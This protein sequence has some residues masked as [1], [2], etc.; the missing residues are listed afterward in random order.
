MPR[1]GLDRD[2]V[3]DAAEEILARDGAGELTLAKVARRLGVRTPSLYH[4]VDGLDGLRRAL[5]LRG[6][7]GLR[8][9]LAE[10]ALGR[11]G[12]DA[13]RALAHAYR[14]WASE[15][16]GLYE[17]TLR[18]QSAADPEDARAAYEVVRIVT[19]GL[20]GYGLEG[21]DA[22]HAT[23][24]LRAALHGFVAIEAADGF[25]LDLDPS[26][27]FERLVDWLAAA[28]AHTAP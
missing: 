5:R 12:D 19:G 1:A 15:H 14:R 16:P 20:R 11:S 10:A 6:I 26:V 7:A 2:A 22:L 25:G 8:D 21:D 18:G 9:A 23:R 28:L 17:L 3:L 4:H 24:I 27:T 13:V